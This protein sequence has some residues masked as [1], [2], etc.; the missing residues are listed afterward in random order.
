MARLLTG[1]ASITGT[2]IVGMIAPF[3]MTSPPTGW[4]VCDGTA[5]N[6]ST[7]PQYAKLFA[8]IA[9][10]WGGSDGTD[11]QVPDLEGVFLR[12][13][14]SHASSNMADGNDFAG[15]SVGAFENDQFQDHWFGDNTAVN[16][17]TSAHYVGGDGGTAPL[18]LKDGAKRNY[19][20]SSNADN[21][22][23]AVDMQYEVD[24][25]GSPYVLIPISN[26]THGTPR[27]GDESRPFNA[28]VKYCIKY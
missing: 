13:T 5:Y 6:S 20:T 10:T 17:T 28:G 19:A 21:N 7:L 26:K 22:H 14:G 2:N 12:G 8:V 24:S 25:A 27:V 3:A 11:F 4:L 1:S 23:G 16:T 9:N 18:R 15:P